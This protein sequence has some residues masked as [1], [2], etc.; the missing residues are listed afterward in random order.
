MENWLRVTLYNYEYDRNNQG[1]QSDDMHTMKEL[2]SL[3]YKLDTLLSVI[4]QQ[5]LVNFIGE[6]EQQ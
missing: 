4:M 2:K 6:H 1:G 5:G 3:Q